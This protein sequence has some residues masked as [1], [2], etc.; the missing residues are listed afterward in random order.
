[1]LQ[2][3]PSQEMTVSIIVALACIDFALHSSTHCSKYYANELSSFANELYY[4]VWD[5]TLHNMDYVLQSRYCELHSVIHMQIT[6]LSTTQCNPYANE[7]YYTVWIVLYRVGSMN[8][9]HFNK[10]YCL[11]NCTYHFRFPSLHC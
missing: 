2:Q 9:T 1:M 7:L 6:L 5:C 11:D 3:F 4:T 8:Y 10:Q